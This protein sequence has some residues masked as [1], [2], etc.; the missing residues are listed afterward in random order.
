[1]KKLIFKPIL[2]GA[3]LLIM[4]TTAFAATYN[5]TG[6]IR[7][8]NDSHPDFQANIGG[9]E[10]GLVS[11][12]LVGKTPTLTNPGSGDGSISSAT[13]FDQWY[14]DVGGVNQSLLYDIQMDNSI[15]ADPNVYTFTSNS[16]FPIDGQLFG[17]QG[18]NHNYH[19]TY[20]INSTFTYK[21][22]ETFSFTGDDDV[23][24]Y[25]DNKLVVDLGGIHAAANGS[26]DLTTLGLTVGQVYDFDLYFA[27]RH[28]T[29]SN[30]RI[31]TSIELSTVPLP[32]ALPLYGAGVA[33]MG[34]IGWRR[35]RKLAAS[36]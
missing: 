1:M 2:V 16:F 17:N 14:K 36:A 6:T 3:S 32:A 8:F 10:T 29:Q 31:D 23:W 33:L 27:E 5:L 25:I 22:T 15:T 7:D 19:F 12:T 30:F 34:L 4:S 9:L 24:V 11:N 35:K 26:V 21:G 28:T 18:R 13:S 20:E